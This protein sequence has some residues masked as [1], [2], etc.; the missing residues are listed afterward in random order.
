MNIEKF[1]QF[2]IDKEHIYPDNCKK[3]N[4]IYKNCEIYSPEFN[5]KYIGMPI[6]YLVNKEDKIIS[7]NKQEVL[8][9]LKLL[10]KTTNED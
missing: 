3:E 10:E 9:I 8:E 6:F 1:K 5:N 7:C 2:L 4:L